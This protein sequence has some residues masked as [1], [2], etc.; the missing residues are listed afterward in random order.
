MEFIVVIAII[1]VLCLILGVN[2]NYI[3]WGITILA[4]ILFGL[5]TLCFAYCIVRLAFAKRKEAN[6]VR[7]DKVKD[8][9][10]EVAF[11]LVEGGEYA[12]I[13]PKEFILENKLYSK[14][15]TYTVMLDMKSKKVYDQY[16]IA[17]CILGLLFS[18]SFCVVMGM[19]LL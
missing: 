14:E 11:Y 13:F 1:L 9:R 18:L 6:F 15:K 10:V 12:C 16:A 4:C 7:F 2:F 19:L 3:L 17:T 8:S 5:M